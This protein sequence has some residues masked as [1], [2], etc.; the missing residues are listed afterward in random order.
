MRKA[1]SVVD[2]TATEMSNLNR[3]FEVSL[4]V[5]AGICLSI[6][7]AVT[8]INKRIFE[9]VEREVRSLPR[10]VYSHCY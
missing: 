8:G 6:V 4:T 7:N 1:M 9:V 2:V 5:A 10:L 3:D